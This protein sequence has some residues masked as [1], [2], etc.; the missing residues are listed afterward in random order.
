MKKSLITG[1]ILFVVFSIVAGIIY[2][3][4]VYLPT[5]IKAR[6]VN[7]LETSL[8]YN[9]DI[10][11]LKY[12]LIRGIIVENLAIY[13]KVRDKENTIL[14]VK[15]IS[16]PVLLLPLIKERKV[17]IPIIHIDS[18]NLYMRYQKDNQ[19]NFSR[20]LSPKPRQQQNKKIAKN[21]FSFLVYKINISG[22]KCVFTD[23][24]LTPIF[25]K[26]IS[27]FN[28]GLIITPLAKISFLIQGKLLMD[29]GAVGKLSLQGNYDLLSKELNS[30]ISLANLIISE[31]NPYLKTLSLSIGSGAIKD[32]SLDFKAKDN[33]ITI[34]GVIS[35]EGL[36][37]SK[38]KLLLSGDI[39]IQPDMAYATDKKTLDYKIIFKFVRADLFGLPYIEKISNI[40]G[41]IGLTENKLWT[42]NL[43]LQAIDSPFVLKGTL[44]NF[45]NPY[46]KLNL[47]SEQ[48][49]L[50]KLL[51]L[52]PRKPQG[53]DLSGTSGADI[54]IES[55]LRKLSLG[56]TKATFD[57]T[58]AKLQAALLKKPLNDIKGRV[59]FA[60]DIVSWSGLSFNYDN[61]LYTTTG[62]LTDFQAPLINLS[63]NSK[64]LDL[65]SALKIKDKII[66]I[67]AFEGKYLNST[68]DIK[69]NM[70]A[71]DNAN[72][73]LDL[74]AELNLKTADALIFLPDA[75]AENLKKVKLDGNLNIKGRFNGRAKDY[76]GWSL[77]ANTTSD[78]FSIYNLKFSN[79]SFN[80][81]QKDGTLN[82]SRFSGSGYSGIINMDFSSD[83]KSDA[84]ACALKFNCSG[85]D[86][87]K[88]KL[89]T[90]LKDS[91]ITG[92]LNINADVNGNLKGP[93]SLE[94]AGTVSIKDG[95][96]WQLNFFKGLGE[97]FLLPKYEK[98]AFKDAFGEFT[99]KDKFISTEN[100]KLT[101]DQLN[102]NCQG[103]LGFNGALD[104]TVYTEVN[105]DLIRDSADL[106][107]FPT[108][109]LGELS[110]TIVTQVSGTIKKP[111]YKIAPLPLDMIK[112]IKNFLLGK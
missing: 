8:N 4:N 35:T 70:D 73:L 99:V 40:S 13:D 51:A 92:T 95:N 37:L 101:S 89:D 10:E 75:L 39:N 22:G 42:N 14:T 49:N 103:K 9:V 32:T 6:L 100:L 7:A 82:I 112:N 18:P 106:R 3:N 60:Q 57:I 53:L 111:K 26:T 28:I 98:I 30:K 17:I 47:H 76:K 31:F 59:D 19:L 25:S 48:L 63:I 69:G 21:K 94:G 23:E 58:A 46:L 97:L 1:I 77:S 62:K 61:T 87:A 85:I 84:P 88:L 83:L 36:E 108:A 44:E 54:N 27:D 74:S 52:I 93:D 56:D 33:L 90:D 109:I 107:K 20:I 5:K 41:D 67:N 68:F 29:K 34:K 45:R 105:K 96:L 16:F 104:F 43:N 50:E 38:E 81:E 55:Y 80:L 71:Q 91:N 78:A 65:K 66:K 72:P 24:R 102:L 2:L 11:K 64:D 110:K 12:N 79:L 86:L 15:E